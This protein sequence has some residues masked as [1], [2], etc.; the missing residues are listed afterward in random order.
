MERK[1]TEAREFL[2]LMTGRLRAIRTTPQV[3]GWEAPPAWLENEL[4]EM[5]R[6]FREFMGLPETDEKEE[7]Q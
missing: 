3:F 1:P 2:G 5:E 6:E 7:G 4:A